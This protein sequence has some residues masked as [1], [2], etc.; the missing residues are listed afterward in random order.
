[1][2][3]DGTSKP[4]VTLS[5][6]LSRTGILQLNKVEAKVEETYFVDAPTNKTAKK[7]KMT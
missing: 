4:K 7:V 1:M 3:K 6:E 2:K 5:F